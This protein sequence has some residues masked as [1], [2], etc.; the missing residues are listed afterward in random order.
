M[1]CHPCILGGP[2]RQ[3]R[4]E[5]EIRIGCLTSAFS[6]AQKRAEMLR[7][8]C[9]LGDPQRQVPGENKRY[10]KWLPPRLA[11]SRAQKRNCYVT[12]AFS[13]VPMPS[14]GRKRNQ[15]WLP[16][17]CLLGGPQEGKNATSPLHSRGF[18]SQARGEKG[19]QN[20]MPHPCLLGS[21]KEGGN[22]MARL[23][24]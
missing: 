10:Q 13:G 23:H 1:L 7:H 16:H 11:F 20:W 22:A 4:G 2:Q 18:P 17:R 9:I 14:T 5:K 24:S 19:N 8:T 3:A 12:P 6:G 15:N 21:P